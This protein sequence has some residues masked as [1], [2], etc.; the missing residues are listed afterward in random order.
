ML[1]VDEEDMLAQMNSMAA[2]TARS[3]QAEIGLE[4]A[5]N[6][7]VAEG[8]ELNDL[9]G[10]RIGAAVDDIIKVALLNPV[11]EGIAPASGFITGTAYSAPYFLGSS[12][13]WTACFPGRFVFEDEIQS[14]LH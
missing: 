2:A 8:Q 7:Y 11:K 1:E 4:H 9:L 3:Q 10:L 14:M 6:G 13:G 5:A 12:P